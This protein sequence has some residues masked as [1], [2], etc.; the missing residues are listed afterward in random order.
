MFDMAPFKAPGPDGFHAGFYQNQWNIVGETVVRQTEEFLKTGIMPMN[1]NDTLVSLIP[2]V[3]NPDMVSQFRPISL[4]NV[5]YKVIT[6]AMTNRIKNVIREL[7]GP[8]QSSFV[9]KR[10]ITDNIIVYQEVLHSLRKKKGNKGF[11]VLKIDLEKAYD[12]LAWKFIQD[13]LDDV[14]FNEVW[15][16]NIMTYITTTRLGVLWN[17][18]QLDWIEPSRGIRQGDT[19]S[20]YIF[21]LCIERLSHIIREAVRRGEWKGIRLGRKGPLIPHLIFADDMVLFSEAIEDQIHVI[22]ECLDKFSEASGQKVRLSKSH[23]M[24]SKNFSPEVAQKIVCVAGMNQTS[25]MGKYLGV[26]SIHGRVTNNMFRPILDRMNNRL[27]GWKAK[28]L[29]MAGRV[30]MAQSVLSTIPYYAM[31]TTLFPVGICENIDKRIRGFIWGNKEGERKIHLMS[32]DTVTKSKERGGLGMRKARE[33]NLAFLAKLKWRFNKERDKLW[34]KVLRSKYAG[35][36]NDNGDI[37]KTHGAFNLCQGLKAASSVV[38]KGI[39]KHARNGE[40]VRFWKDRWIESFPLCDVVNAEL[41][42]DQMDST[43]AEYWQPQGWK[44]EII[45]DLLPEEVM[46]KLKAYSLSNNKDD[47]DE[48]YWMLEES[49]IFSVSSA[50]HNSNNDNSFMHDKGWENLWKIKVPNRMSTFL[51][52]VRHERILCNGERRRRHITNN[53]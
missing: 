43:V 6:K 27:E 30:T 17:G 7:I 26:P 50:Y 20:P 10:Q 1:M 49:G 41:L 25:D 45:S 51:W 14:G 46:E 33:M 11:M 3:E 9:P 44:W 21:V 13:T 28:Y 35:Q 47:M 22:K 31:Q 16:R 4:C 40:N 48:I 24:F 15:I 52:L 23:I 5:C 36:C 53:G 19:I 2:K 32:W 29:S 12:K 38:E 42:P 8:E 18:E 34:V 37:L 39:R